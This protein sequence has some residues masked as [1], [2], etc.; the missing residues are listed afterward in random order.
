MNQAVYDKL[1]AVAKQ[2]SLVTYADLARVA[3]LDVAADGGVRHLGTILDEIALH[4]IRAGRP[5]LAVVVIRAD[6]GVP[7][8]GLFDFARKHGM[9]RGRDET[10]FFSDELRRVYEAWADR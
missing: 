5:L 1:I 8:K 9:L 6:R 4:E 7:S 2:R 3:D 10:G